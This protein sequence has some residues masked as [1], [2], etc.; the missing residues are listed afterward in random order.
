MEK[1]EKKNKE[2]KKEKITEEGEQNKGKTDGA[3]ERDGVD[4]WVKDSLGKKRREWTWGN[5]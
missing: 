4:D 5:S 1:N 3:E 2:K